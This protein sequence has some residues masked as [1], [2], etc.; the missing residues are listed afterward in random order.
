M[1]AKQVLVSGATG[2]QGGALARL[3]IQRGHKVRALTR[4]KDSAAARS[5]ASLGA[6]LVTA[7][8]LD[9]AALDKAVNGMDAVFAM[10]TPFEAGV[11]AET[12][13]GITLADAAQAAGAHL[14]YT[15]V[16][17]ADLNT[18]I[19][20]FDSKWAVEQHLRK[21]GA[22]ATVIA[23]VYFMENVG[24]VRQQL[25]QGVLPSPLSPDRK[26]AQIAVGDIAAAAAAII[27]A[28]ERHTGKR[29]DLS[30]YELSGREQAEIMSRVI[31]R[32]FQYFKLPM[33]VI[34]GS[35]GEDGVIMYQW[36][37]N[38]GY[39]IDY[40]ALRQ[41]FPEITWTTFESWAKSFD[42]DA[43]FKG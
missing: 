3:L 18:G 43:F 32:P 30:G 5:L 7:D 14:V 6:E 15:S 2:K 35:M 42:W 27:E 34:R 17:N 28:P 20:H 40:A 9:R 33:E 25:S 8:L 4:N 22:R 41:A 11:D 13:Q 1:A 38:T 39:K 12:R 36:F 10:T 24:F 29:Y 23:P 21:S 26:L 31:G 16:G 37:E 19:P